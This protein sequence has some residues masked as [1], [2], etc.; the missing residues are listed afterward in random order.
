MID[1]V[2]TSQFQTYQYFTVLILVLL[3]RLSRLLCL[4]QV[5]STMKMFI[6]VYFIEILRYFSIDILFTARIIIFNLLFRGYSGKS[7]I[8]VSPI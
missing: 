1:I 5:P 2:T 7:Y 3:K 6:Y 8:N 4:T